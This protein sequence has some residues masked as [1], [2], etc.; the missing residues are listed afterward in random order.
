[1]VQ[2]LTETVEDESQLLMNDEGEES[3][4]MDNYPNDDANASYEQIESTNLETR[5]SAQ[6]RLIKVEN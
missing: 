1:M 6:E 5:K 4:G 2:G 3:S